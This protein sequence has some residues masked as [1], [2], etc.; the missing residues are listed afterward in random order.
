MTIKLIE[1]MAE[2]VAQERTS[3]EQRAVALG[4]VE[5]A[6][7]ADTP[8]Y[9]ALQAQ[10]AAAGINP[11]ETLGGVVYN[12]QVWQS[13]NTGVDE[14]FDVGLAKI[15]AAGFQR[16][17]RLAEASDLFLDYSRRE[18]DSSPQYTL[19]K[20]MCFG[21]GDWLSLA[22]ERR[23]D[24]LHAYVDPENL[25][26]RKDK[27][28]WDGEPVYNQEESP[29]PFDITGIQ[30]YNGRHRIDT[31]PPELVAFM[32]GGRRSG[33]SSDFMAGHT[34]VSVP[35]ANNVNPISRLQINRGF[36]FSGNHAAARGV[37]DLSKHEGEK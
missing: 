9:E 6:L 14:P 7:T 24:L 31:L 8:D 13:E 26:W 32:Y 2:R 35:L 33:W 18:P 36:S 23:Q 21:K 28:I 11:V 12:G 16:F 37:Y 30:D 22:F 4:E 25:V 19:A 27:Y 17:P 34:H 10:I 15:Q 20:N 5:S 1:L 3:L 29:E